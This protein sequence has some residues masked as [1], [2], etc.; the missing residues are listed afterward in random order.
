MELLSRLMKPKIVCDG[1]TEEQ[2]A[3]FLANNKVSPGLKVTIA[4]P[5]LL[6]TLKGLELGG[7]GSS[8]NIGSDGVAMKNVRSFGSRIDIS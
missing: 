7:L 6:E 2:I 5:R 8:Y 3:T 4:E 1:A